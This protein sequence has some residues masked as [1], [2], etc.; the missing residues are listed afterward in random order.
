MDI[1]SCY[2]GPEISPEQ[3]IP[4]HFFLFL[5]KGILNGYDGSKDVTLRSGDYCI[6]RKNYLARYNKQTENNEFEKVVVIFDEIFLKQFQEKY[7]PK[8]ERY[9]PKEAFILLGKNEH[10][11][12]FICSLMP[13]YNGM[14][15]IEEGIQDTKREE[16]LLILLEMYPDL[17][18]ILF[19]FGKPEKI[20]LEEFMNQNYKFNV[21]IERFAYLT[22][23]S[24]SAFK[25]DFKQIFNN[26]PSRWLIH[27]RLQEAH[28]LIDKKKQKP[29][30]IYVDLGFE[31]L[32][33][34]SHAF[35]KQFGIS[36]KSLL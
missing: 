23:R 10:I 13:Y 17:T 12:A 34:F 30:E 8:T 1:K 29:S 4:E 26:T 31:D 36:P 28:F 15:K 20:N 7:Q 32:S 11:P 9:K 22:G 24:L 35:K 5:A 16:L 27:K 33:H 14:G 6:V 18:G 3:F 21:G 25:R 19:D 2:I